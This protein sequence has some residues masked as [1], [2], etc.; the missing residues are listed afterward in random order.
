M[1]ELTLGA[2]RGRLA[3][4]ARSLCYGTAI[5]SSKIQRKRQL[6]CK[7]QNYLSQGKL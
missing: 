5:R 3:L 6:K 2:V 7:G 4:K 1:P